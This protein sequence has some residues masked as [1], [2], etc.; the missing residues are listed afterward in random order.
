MKRLLIRRLELCSAVIL[1]KIVSYLAD[2]PQIPPT[3][4]F[5]WT[6][7]QVVLA[8]LQGNPRCF[9]PFVGNRIAEISEA[10]PVGCWHHIRGTE[11]PI[12]CASR[13]MFLSQLAQYKLWW[14]GPQWLRKKVIGWAPGTKFLEHPIPSEE[15]ELY[16]AKRCSCSTG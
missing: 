12:D 15:K 9:K 6:D 10:L 5:A 13:G 7:S 3:D 4:I 8:W 1:S 2:T 16:I 14:H 11:N